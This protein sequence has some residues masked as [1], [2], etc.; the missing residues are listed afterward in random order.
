M[1]NVRY[2][3]VKKNNQHVNENAGKNKI[4]DDELLDF[5]TEL[6]TAC[7]DPTIPLSAYVQ[8]QP[9]VNEI[10]LTKKKINFQATTFIQKCD[11]LSFGQI[12]TL[13]SMLVFVSQ[14]E[15]HYKKHVILPSWKR[16]M[17]IFL[18]YFRSYRQF[19]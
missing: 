5:V 13:K 17:R 14:D 8:L 4:Y 9:F 2:Y 3:V 6:E 11:Q 12:L 10:R 1:Q 19:K 16:L 7:R 15:S 18:S